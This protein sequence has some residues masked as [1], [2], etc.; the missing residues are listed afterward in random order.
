MSNYFS[1]FWRSTKTGSCAFSPDGPEGKKLSS[2]L[3]ADL[4]GINELPFELHLVKSTVGRHGLIYSDDLSGIED[5]W[6]DFL[7]NEFAIP[8]LSEKL[9]SIIES[10]LTGEEAVDWIS[11]K[12]HGN[13]ECRTYY[14]LR[15]NKIL[16]V[17]DEEHSMFNSNPGTLIVPCFSLKKIK[18]YTVFHIPDEE[19][20]IWKIQSS[21]VLSEKLKK[22]IQKAK[23]TGVTFSKD[24]VI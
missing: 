20:F 15:F 22:A 5:I 8:I 18:N 21:F 16:D 6:E 1:L 2:D 12:I 3:I 9:K 13:G 19:A 23:I 10:E 14:I 17:L 11:A 24:R 4:E 7:C